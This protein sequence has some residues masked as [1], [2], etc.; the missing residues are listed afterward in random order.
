MKLKD[1]A[2]ISTSLGDDASFTLDVGKEV[3]VCFLRNTASR[4]PWLHQA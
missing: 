1:T 3:F 2:I 4:G